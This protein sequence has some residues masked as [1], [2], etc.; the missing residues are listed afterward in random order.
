MTEDSTLLRRYAD[1]HAEDAFAELVRRHLTLVYSVALRQVSGD[2]HLAHDVA[3][4]VFTA[5][6]RKARELAGHDAITGWLYR[7]THYAASDTVRAERR[8]RTREQE[9]HAMQEITASPESA[10]ELEKL[11][12]LLDT[13]I[14]E[15]SETDR[16]AVCLRFFENR[17]YAEIGTQLRL[18][19]NTARM[20]VERALDKLHGLLAR[21]G[22]TSTTAALAL[23]L[24][25]QAA[26]TA[27]VGLAATLTHTALVATASAAAG[28]TLLALMNTP[29]IAFTTAA[30]I[31]AVSLGTAL[32]LRS[33][34]VTELA[35]ARA[36]RAAADVRI[37]DLESKLATQAKATAAADSDNATL[38][39]A[40]ESA[41][42]QLA[43]TPKP[44]AVPITRDSVEARYTRAKELD[45]AGRL[46]EALAEYLWCYD[47]GMPQVSMYGGV[48]NSFLLS[49]IAELGDRFPAARQA[50]QQRREAA[51][52]R[53]LA[54]TDDFNAA[55]DY[56]SLNR[57]LKVEAESLAL[58]DTLPPDA[59]KRTTLASLLY[60]Q[61]AAAQRYADAAAGQPYAQA[62]SRFEL[63]ANRI[64]NGK[65][66]ELTEKLKQAQRSM[67]IRQTA[68]AIE[69]LAGAGDFAH[70]ADLA[71]R[72]LDYDS[73]PETIALLEKHAA[74]AG[75]PNL[76]STLRAKP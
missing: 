33:E 7:S 54:S 67:V 37:A 26:T 63:F 15:L 21:R 16:D 30:I 72:L 47:T 5:L 43:T 71:L 17:S 19:E 42:A 8:R 68:T 62:S 34:A 76:I 3:Q 18:S 10:P 45:K 27:P 31:S 23:A 57:V 58:F 40:V 9:A 14:G 51:R 66:P 48:R 75:H 20:R 1:T 61:L 60:E 55:Q 38:L 32:Y 6:A 46:E 36:A 59:P 29:K 70:A 28:W 53:F 50:L 52:Q 12:P 39:A 56:T 24:P 2:A 11:R 65:T 49:A 73:S 13:A 69:V 35:A 44:A 74:R 22:V 64:P 4:T 25:G 41:A